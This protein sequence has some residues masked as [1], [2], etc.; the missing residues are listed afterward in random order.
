MAYEAPSTP[1]D[2]LRFQFARAEGLNLNDPADVTTIDLSLET[3]Q[4]RIA[5]RDQFTWMFGTSS[6]P[7]VADTAQYDLRS[8]NS[9]AMVDLMAV[10]LMWITRSQWLRPK[11]R[12]W[13][14][15]QKAVSTDSGTPTNYVMVAESTAELWPTPSSVKTIQVAYQKRAGKVAGDDDILVPADFHDAL[16]V[17]SRIH[18]RL[19][20]LKEPLS[21]N[22]WT[23]STYTGPHD[24]RLEAL[25]AAYRI[26]VSQWRGSS[27]DPVSK[28]L[29]LLYPDEM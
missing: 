14:N 20:M 10:E 25:S 18:Y 23:N 15:R 17:E 12:R 8:V 7:T 5:Q 11:P 13:L 6:F 16:L 22:Q 9:A 27:V 26:D 3:G 24:R 28:F 1:L 21:V 4:R 29:E 2:A 19:N